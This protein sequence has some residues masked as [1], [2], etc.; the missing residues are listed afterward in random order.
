ML[1][2]VRSLT[3][4]PLFSSILQHYDFAELYLYPTLS[5]HGLIGLAHMLKLSLPLPISGFFRVNLET[6]MMQLCPQGGEAIEALRGLIEGWEQQDAGYF[7]R[8]LR[9][10]KV[11]ET[12]EKVYTELFSATDYESALRLLGI[13]VLWFTGE[14]R[15]ALARDQPATRALYCTLFK[16]GKQRGVL[17]H[18]K[19]LQVSREDQWYFPIAY[20]EIYAYQTQKDEVHRELVSTLSQ[21]VSLTKAHIPKASPLKAEQVLLSAQRLVNSEKAAGLVPVLHGLY[22]RQ[23]HVCNKLTWEVVQLDCQVHYSCHGHLERGERECHLCEKREEEVSLVPS[24]DY[25]QT[26]S[27]VPPLTLSQPPDLNTIIIDIAP[28]FTDFVCKVCLRRGETLPK[29]CSCLCKACWIRYL[30]T[31]CVLPTTVKCLLCEKDANSKVMAKTLSISLETCVNCKSLCPESSLSST[32]CRKMCKLCILCS[33]QPSK[34]LDANNRC[35]YC[36]KQCCDE[37]LGR[38]A[39]CSLPCGHDVHNRCLRSGKCPI[40]R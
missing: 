20:D 8:Q 29:A 23:C 15:N 7:W 12:I 27:Q 34:P 16:R 13:S 36:P 39:F 5:D 28:A 18:R 11:V 25:L 24:M 31:Y 30:S 26:V 21:L 37:Q 3:T 2:E 14:T 19:D 1:A 38:E 6:A 17:V 32:N 22:G 33:S 35:A 10:P 40:C 4:P 9:D